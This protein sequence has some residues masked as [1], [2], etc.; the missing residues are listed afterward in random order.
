MRIAI[1]T[2]ARH[3]EKAACDGGC[4]RRCLTNSIAWKHRQLI[5]VDQAIERAIEEKRFRRNG[6][7]FN[8]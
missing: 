1:D 5:N 2:M 8:V 3:V 4:K 6:D 7:V